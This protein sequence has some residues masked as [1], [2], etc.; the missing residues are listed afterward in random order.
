MSPGS[1]EV[2]NCS[3]APPLSLAV[4]AVGS[5]QTTCRRLD[6][7]GV[8]RRHPLDDIRPQIRQAPRVGQRFDPLPSQI[9]IAAPR[10]GLDQQR[11]L[12]R[13]ERR[14]EAGK[15]LDLPP[16]QGKRR[17][18]TRRRRADLDRCVRL[19]SLQQEFEQS[20][21]KRPEAFRRRFERLDASSVAC[22]P[23]TRYLLERGSK[24]FV[25]FLAGQLPRPP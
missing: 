4:I 13:T 17:R 5:P 19:R 16:T 10:E 3:R 18:C 22:P 11:Q 8:T 20:R 23:V 12:H 21:R 9:L 2:S 1:S 25:Q 24:R 15:L 7:R 14:Q 6:R